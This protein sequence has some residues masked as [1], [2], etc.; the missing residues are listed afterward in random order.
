MI[1]QSILKQSYKNQIIH[2]TFALSH[3]AWNIKKNSCR[4]K[5]SVAG[6]KKKKS[7]RKNTSVVGGKKKA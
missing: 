7:L 5:T 4:I 1:N 6:K 2:K 3:Y